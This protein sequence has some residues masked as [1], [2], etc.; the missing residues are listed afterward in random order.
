MQPITPLPRPD[1]PRFAKVRRPFLDPIAQEKNYPRFLPPP[2]SQS[3]HLELPLEAIIPQEAAAAAQAGKLVFHVACDTGGV[4]GDQT[5][6]AIAE[7]MEAR[8]T[9]AH[10]ADKPAFLYIGGD[11]VYYNGL[12]KDYVPQFYDPY[13]Y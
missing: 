2:P 9:A 10:G 7:A 11:V 6:L 13:K 8:I 1:A 4:H 12:S 3:L 5:E